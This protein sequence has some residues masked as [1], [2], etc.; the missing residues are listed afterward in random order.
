MMI[1]IVFLFAIPQIPPG[2]ELLDGGDGTT[3]TEME[4]K[5]MEEPYPILVRH[6]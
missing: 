6:G 1:N 4:K 2:S 5:A 3:E